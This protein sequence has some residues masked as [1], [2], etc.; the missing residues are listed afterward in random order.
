VIATAPTH[1]QALIFNGV[2]GKHEPG[3]VVTDPTLYGDLAG[4]AT[5]AVVVALNGIGISGTPPQ[6]NYVLQ[7]D[8]VNLMWTPK[9]LPSSNP[10]LGGDLS[11]VASSGTVVKLRGYALSTSVPTS[12]QLMGYNGANWGPV[13]APTFNPSF[14]GDISGFYTGITVTRL[15]GV[16]VSNAQPQDGQVMKY[17]ASASQWQAQT[18]SMPWSGISSKPT[19]VSTW[20][21]DAGYLTVVPRTNLG[22]HHRQ[23]DH[24]VHL[25]Q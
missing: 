2:S 8:D 10:T 21:N 9:A 5:A 15:Q 3:T 12:G 24:R 22:E 20:T 18:S 23:A 11:G 16:Q 25:H 17:N 4:T 19:L 6:A 7:Y 13:A 1:G 14:I